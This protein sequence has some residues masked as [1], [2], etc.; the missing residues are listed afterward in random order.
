M[1][2]HFFHRE[3]G[4]LLRPR[5]PHLSREIVYHIGNVQARTCNQAHYVPGVAD[6]HF[7][8]QFAAGGEMLTSAD[9]YALQD[10]EASRPSV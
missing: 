3:L 10:V 2:D 6:A 5:D 4:S 7:Q 1:N 9:S 8:D